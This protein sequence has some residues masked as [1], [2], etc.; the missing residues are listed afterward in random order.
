MIDVE[1]HA[2]SESSADAESPAGTGHKIA[3]VRID[4]PDRRNALD[5]DHCQGLRDG[6][7]QAVDAGARAIVLTGVGTSFCAGADLDQ[8]YGEAFTEALYAALHAITDAAVPV[9]AAVNGPAIGAG[10]Q[11]ALAADLRVAAERASFAIP[12]ARLGL[13]VDPWTLSRLAALAG[14]GTARAVVIGCETVAAQRAIDLGLVQR[15][16]E[17]DVAVAWAQE[18]AGL[19][20]LTLAYSKRAFNEAVDAA[21][22]PSAAVTAAY[23]ACWASD[24]AQ[25]GRRARAEKRPPIFQGK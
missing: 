18:L 10:L 6:V 22:R 7:G 14:G 15:S 19:A 12:T 8:V 21:A 9:I 3:I 20:P 16:G 1:I 4:R 23:E 2:G 17:L 25:E 24:D 13:A 11:L 5:I